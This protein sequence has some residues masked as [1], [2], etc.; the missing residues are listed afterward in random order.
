MKKLIRS[1]QALNGKGRKVTKRAGGRFLIAPAP[2]LR[3]DF[4]LPATGT[5][6]AEDAPPLVISYGTRDGEYD[7]YAERL[8]Q[9]CS[10]EGIASDIDTIPPCGRANACLFKPSFIKFK[11]LT[12]NRP[13]VWVDA[14]AVLTGPIDLPGGG[15]DVGTL[16]NSRHAE[17]N[18]KA[19]LCIAFRPTLGAL[20]FLETWE[21]LCS[22][23]WLKPGLDHA[24]FND[25]RAIL[26]NTYSEIDL[27]A[28]LSGKLVRDL[29]KKKEARV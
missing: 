10:G 22:E 14:D 21:H 11:L 16:D 24:R 4:L 23:P 26:V 6:P 27:T 7:L 29:G 1:L 28:A 18:P 15:W 2:N 12:H 20:R 19:A 9:S 8:R 13:V 17:T 25:T 5:A 3:L